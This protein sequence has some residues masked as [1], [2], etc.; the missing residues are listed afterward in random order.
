MA[1]NLSSIYFVNVFHLIGIGIECL[2]CEHTQA[3]AKA[4]AHAIARLRHR[5]PTIARLSAFNQSTQ[6]IDQLD[7]Q[8]NIS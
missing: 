1:I 2:A 7:T 6:P 8:A 4:K 5:Q 3:K